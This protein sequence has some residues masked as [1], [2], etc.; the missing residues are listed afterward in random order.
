MKLLQRRRDAALAEH[1]LIIEQDSW[2]V[3][4]R[5]IRM[6]IARHREAWI[7]GAALTGGFIVGLLPL[8]HLSRAVSL[9]ASA[10]SFM[11]RTPIGALLA[12]GFA[13]SREDAGT[14]G[15]LETNS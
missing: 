1:R 15:P 2:R 8:R 7:V 9:T 14:P 5:S 12:D 3:K 11:M 10:A 6:Y 13:R 4:T